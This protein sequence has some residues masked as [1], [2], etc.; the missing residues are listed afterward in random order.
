MKELAKQM[1]KAIST[2]RERRFIADEAILETVLR[3]N[4]WCKQ[5]EVIY[6]HHGQVACYAFGCT[7]AD[8][9]RKEAVTKTLSDI[10]RQIHDH[11][12]YPHGAG[13]NPYISLRVIDAI[14]Q[15]AL[16]KTEVKV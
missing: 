7:E 13:I 4:G 5:S 16:K 11:A 10:K 2:E 9:V 14:I 6:D 3:E 1:S 12:I 8:K 15:D